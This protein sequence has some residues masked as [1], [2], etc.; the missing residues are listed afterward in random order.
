ME[1]FDAIQENLLEAVAGFHQI[2]TGAY[3]IRANGATAARNSTEHIEIIP[4]EN[5]TG[6][7]IWIKP[8]TK[9]ESLHMPVILV[10]QVSKRW[11]IMIFILEKTQ[12]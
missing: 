3:N 5:G 9:K 4:K 7:D 10:R 6:I 1:K 11:S 2:P 12:M 8:G